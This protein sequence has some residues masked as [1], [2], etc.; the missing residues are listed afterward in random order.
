MGETQ[1]MEEHRRVLKGD[2]WVAWRDWETAQRRGVPAPP[3]QRPAPED[4]QR[5]D[6]VAPEDLT[7]GTLAVREAIG[8]RRSRRRFSDELLTVEELSFLLWAT[9]GVRERGGPGSGTRVYRTV[10][11]GGGRHPLETYLIVNQVTGLEPGLYRY[12][13]LEHQLCLLRADAALAERV[14][15]VCNGQAFVGRGAVVFVWTAVP[16]RTEWR[17]GIIAPKMIALDAGH[18]CQNLYLAAEAIGAGACA[19]GIY[20]QEEMDRLLGV[21][22][23]EEFAIYVATVGRVG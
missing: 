4:A 7:G 5:I 16:S 3:L 14:S 9:Q 17:F 20:I 2:L 6:L 19:V 13:S 12:L 10:P 11:S 15:D 18:V 22:G 21:D 23:Q 1:S 8:Q